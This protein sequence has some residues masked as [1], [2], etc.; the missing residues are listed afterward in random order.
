MPPHTIISCPVQTAECDH[1]PAGASIVAVDVQASAIGS[2]RP[3]VSSPEEELPSPPQTIA[4][5]PSQRIVCPNRPEGAPII[6]I[7]VQASVAGWYR[8]PVSKK[9]VGYSAV[10][11]PHTTITSTARAEVTLAASAS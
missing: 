11:P 5:L 4:S 6:E 8:A 3:P 7:G 10:A 9:V 2:Y 1:R